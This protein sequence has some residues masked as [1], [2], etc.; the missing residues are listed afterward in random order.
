MTRSR[1]KKTDRPHSTAP[2][3]D[4]PALLSAVESR[5][6]GWSFAG[7]M[8]VLSLFYTWPL[9]AG[10]GGRLLGRFGDYYG[11]VFGAVWELW[12]TKFLLLDLQANPLIVQMLAGPFSSFWYSFAAFHKYL[13]LM[14]PAT[15]AVGPVGAYN[16]FLI[17]NYV[18]AGCSMYLLARELTGSRTAAALAGILFAFNPYHY[19]HGI[20]HM[21]LASTWPMPLTVFAVLRLER[22][23]SWNNAGLLVLS[24][25]LFHVYCS[26]YYYLFLPLLFSAWLIVRF[27]DYF[28]F[29][30]SAWKRVRGRLAAVPLSRRVAVALAA[31]ALIAG[32]A[33]F[34]QKYMLPAASQL[35]RPLEWQERFKLSGAN[36]LAPGVDHPLFG[37]ITRNFVPI[38]RNVTEST[39]YIGWVTLALGLWGLSRARRDRRAWLMLLFGAGAFTFT[40]G[41]YLSLG[42]LQVPMP[43]LLLHKLAPFI[44]VISRYSI[45]AQLAL[46]ALAAFGAVALLKR[47]GGRSGELALAALI[48]L[49]AV[50]YARPTGVTEVMARPEQAPPIYAA[51]SKLDRESIVFEYPPCASTGLAYG[52]YL[53][54]QTIHQKT[55]FNRHF[56]TTTIPERFLP[57]W[58][59]MDYPAA[60]SDPNNVRLLKYFGVEYLAFHDRENQNPPSL[61]LPDIARVPGLELE[62][63][64]G[65]ERLYRVSAEPA[66]V[67]LSF[68]TI[69][70]Y[71]YLEVRREAEEDGF[72]A[73]QA[74]GSGEGRLG[75]RIMKERAALTVTSLTDG[76]QRVTIHALAFSFGQDRTLRVRTPDGRVGEI[77]LGTTPREIM[78]AELEPAPGGS[79]DL[80]LDTP[81]GAAD[82][83]AG[84]GQ[85]LRASVALAAVRVETVE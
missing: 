82:I 8:L 19:A 67:M 6:G 58:R 54:F 37:G 44:R 39:A 28:V 12:A 78:L 72:M 47:L 75:W 77:P 38:R 65:R 80:L 3:T 29:D 33:V 46:S 2:V 64:F 53:Y 34:Y 35:E 74:L 1:R 15:A 85:S 40:L 49:A 27:A 20:V 30:F 51:M 43:S 18:L 73:P 76:P 36:Y 61:A 48:A 45:F 55:L 5:L 31:L 16:V 83:P 7:I 69:P 21:D 17:L 71:N 60:L 9:A 11:D 32:A 41:P 22:E 26:L 57:F 84:G 59:D 10:L 70:Y 42:V 62:Q 25:L 56:E 68:Q 63:D 66:T 52:D 24:L 13:F 81:E 4:R 14:V 23:R 79:L 50:E